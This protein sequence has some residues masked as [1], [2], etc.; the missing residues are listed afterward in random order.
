MTAHICPECKLLH[1]APA[2]PGESEAVTLARIAAD[3]AY[4][5]EQLRA[6]T[7]RHIADT[8]ADAAEEIADTEADAD[9]T[10]A[11]AEA[12]LI[13][14]AIEASDT[15]PAE[16]IAPA[17]EPEPVEDE[18]EDAPPPA[19]DHQPHEP[20]RRRGLGVW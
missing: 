19:E 10:A 20:A 18:P 4:K 7:D 6:R 9:V 3:S 2:E 12:E 14:A 1:D 5:I 15:D 11:V 8:E 17:A 16:I 13:G